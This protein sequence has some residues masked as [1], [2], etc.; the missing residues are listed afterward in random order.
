M[1]YDVG[2]GARAALRAR[3]GGADRLHGLHRADHA[4]PAVHRPGHRQ[5]DHGEAQPDMLG[6]TAG[7]PDNAQGT[8]FFLIND[9]GTYFLRKLPPLEATP[10]SRPRR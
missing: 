7:G 8:H 3:G 5:A 9:S 10:R 2:A 6:R 4:G 1:T